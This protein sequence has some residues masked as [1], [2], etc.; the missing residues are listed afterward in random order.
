MILSVRLRNLARPTSA[1]GGPPERSAATSAP[2]SALAR[3][4]CAEP[5]LGA[6][7]YWFAWR[8]RSVFGFVTFFTCLVSLAPR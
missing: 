8:A 4:C 5:V 3:C 7:P 2:G 1:S 6:A